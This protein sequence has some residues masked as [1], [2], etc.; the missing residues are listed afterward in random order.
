M[1]GKRNLILEVNEQIFPTTSFWLTIG[2]IIVMFWTEES[3]VYN[4]FWIWQ[5]QRSNWTWIDENNICWW[6]GRETNHC[7]K[8]FKKIYFFFC[9]Y[10]KSIIF[11]IILKIYAARLLSCIK[12]GYLFRLLTIHEIFFYNLYKSSFFINSVCENVSKQKSLKN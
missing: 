11:N 1:T 5:H 12:I 4:I 8:T 3:L 10:M 9:K 2:T 6:I 7:D